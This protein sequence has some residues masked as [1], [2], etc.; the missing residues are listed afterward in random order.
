MLYRSYTPASPLADFIED[1]WLYDDYR[2]AHLRQRI[3]PSGTTELGINL[4]DNEFRI[5]DRVRPGLCERFSGEIVSGTYER[6]FVIDTAEETSVLGVHTRSSDRRHGAAVDHVFTPVNRGCPG[7]N[8]E[9]DE[10]RDLFG[11]AGPADRNSS[12]RVHQALARADLIGPAAFCEPSDEAMRSGCFDEAGRD[13]V[14]A[15]T[16]RPD[17][18]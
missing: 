9:G 4:R 11:P 7:G 13:G 2:P 6:F 15:D 10:F 18:L 3:L 5:Y 14:H 16:D 17:F 12:K 1:C 8:E